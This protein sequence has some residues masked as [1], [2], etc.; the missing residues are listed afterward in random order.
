MSMNNAMRSS[1]G[2]LL[3]GPKTAITTA[4]AHGS[5]VILMN[6]ARNSVL[7][8]RISQIVIQEPPEEKQEQKEEIAR[9]DMVESTE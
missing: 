4:T 8:Q 5:D 1:A 2:S 6:D 7:C 9:D 3:D